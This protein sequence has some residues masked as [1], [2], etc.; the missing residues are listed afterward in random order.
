MTESNFLE[1][2]K[3]GQR[4]VADGATGTNL[5]TRGLPR[6]VASEQWVLEKPD[7]IMRLEWDFIQAG[8][9]IVL[10][11][12]FGAN[13]FRLNEAGFAERSIEINHRAVELARK[14]AQDLPVFIAGS[15]GPLGKLLKPYGPILPDE[16]VSAYMEQAQI[17][18]DAGVDLLVIET[19]FDLNE[20]TAAVRAAHA[21]SDL[22]LVVS[23][24]YDRG[25][26]TMMGV[27]PTKMAAALQELS[28]D[29]LGIN[30]GRSLEDNYKAL[31][32][33][34]QATQLPIWFKPNAGLPEVD[35]M[36]NTRYT[37]APNSM[38][39][40]TPAWIAAGASIIGGCCGTTPDHLH[41]IATAVQGS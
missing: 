40:Q 25:T 29:V 27:N 33:L 6:G 8:A 21:V 7:E 30:C 37:L 34:R 18:T 35:E 36:G 39:E 23:F 19:Q 1:C 10:T 24:S 31:L 16:A 22:P 11:C 4:L 28:V 9:Q 3:A 20:A 14:A 15:I 2:L 12:T 13:P 41:A 17:L 32:E 38:A 26:R 5:L